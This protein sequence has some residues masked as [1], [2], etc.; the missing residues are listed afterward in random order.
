VRVSLI[1][2]L[3][4]KKKNRKQQAEDCLYPLWIRTAGTNGIE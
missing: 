1:P 2:E 3:E 4:G